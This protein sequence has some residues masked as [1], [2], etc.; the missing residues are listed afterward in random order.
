MTQKEYD[1]MVEIFGEPISIYSDEDAQDDGILTD[2]SELRIQFNGKI[3]NRATCGVTTILQLE[4]KDA[5]IIKN[6]LR[7][8][9]ENS[10]KDREGSDAWGTFEADS[11]F[12]NQKLWLVLNEHD[13]YTLMLPSEY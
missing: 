5:A 6:R 3:I 7:Y 2:V 11:R 9:A 1:A 10:T 8:I 12:G 13:L 4:S